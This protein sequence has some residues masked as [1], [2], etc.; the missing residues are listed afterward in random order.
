MIK[1]IRSKS[2]KGMTLVELIVATAIIGV[3]AIGLIQM[4]T[5]GFMVVSK[6]GKKAQ[7]AY[8][9]QTEV[10]S[11]L[12]TK[13]LLEPQAGE[14]FELTIGADIV[15]IP[16]RKTQIQSELSNGEQVEIEI[17]QPKN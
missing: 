5:M 1:H 16:G 10:E 11:T 7:S 13:H 15:T 17:F 8:N 12:Q 14:T 3:V 2:N 9:A 4:F 6:A